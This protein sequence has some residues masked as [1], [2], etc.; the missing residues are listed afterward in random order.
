MKLPI[1][2]ALSK[3]D[4]DTKKEN[5]ADEIVGEYKGYMK[6]VEGNNRLGTN[7]NG[8]ADY[9]KE[10]EVMVEITRVSNHE[11]NISFR[12]AAFP[13]FIFNNNAV[14]KED[15]SSKKLLIEG[16]WIT[17]WGIIGWVDTMSKKL[18]LD[19]N[20]VRYSQTPNSGIRPESLVNRYVMQEGYDPYH[21]KTV[22]NLEFESSL[23]RKTD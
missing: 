14:S 22:F 12:S 6:Y 17:G 9:M 19:I 8:C 23:Q 13:D 3:S 10:G 1:S 16:D 21:Y 20:P 15:A 18:I 4:P 7:V 11:V 2:Q 5:L